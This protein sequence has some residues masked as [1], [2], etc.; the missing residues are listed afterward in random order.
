MGGLEA[1]Y[2]KKPSAVNPYGDYQEGP[3]RFPDQYVGKVVKSLYNTPAGLP[4]QYKFKLV[5]MRRKPEDIAASLVN[6]SNGKANFEQTLESVNRR[7]DMTLD[8]INQ[9]DHVSKIEIW[10]NDVIDHP[11]E[12]FIKI[13]DFGFPINPY[14]AALGVEPEHYHFGE[15]A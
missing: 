4:K 6:V 7:V 1:L 9:A 11:I 12:E 13:R 2:S 3:D 5:F 10:M 15:N 14:K 8:E